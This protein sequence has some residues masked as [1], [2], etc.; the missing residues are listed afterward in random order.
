MR[1]RYIHT[2]KQAIRNAKST[3]K[4]MFNEAEYRLVNTYGYDFTN[5]EYF[6]NGFIDFLSNDDVYADWVADQKGKVDDHDYELFA[7]IR[8]IV[9]W[10][11]L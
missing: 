4:A 1:N 9:D 11:Y 10:R 2:G 3:V 7:A 8:Y 6:P 5:K